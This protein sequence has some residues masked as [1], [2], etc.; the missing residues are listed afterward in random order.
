MIPSCLEKCVVVWHFMSAFFSALD[1]KKKTT[2]DFWKRLLCSEFPHL[3]FN[4]SFPLVFSVLSFLVP[5]FLFLLFP[6]SLCYSFLPFFFSPSFPLFPLLSFFTFF[7]CFLLPLLA[8]PRDLTFLCPVLSLLHF[9]FLFM[10]LLCF[11]S[12]LSCLSL[13]TFI[14]LCKICFLIICSET[15]HFKCLLEMKY[16][17]I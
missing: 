14:L 1:N 5:F 11:F 12:S 15:T 6:L 10:V 9:F 17:R 13:V 3:V 4:S 7:S 2:T 8:I 16:A